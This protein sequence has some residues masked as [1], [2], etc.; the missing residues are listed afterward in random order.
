MGYD[1]TIGSMS[2]RDMMML[3]SRVQWLE[4]GSVKE[5]GGD[6]ISGLWSNGG[7]TCHHNAA[8]TRAINKACGIVC[9]VQVL[10]T[11]S[12]SVATNYPIRVPSCFPCLARAGATFNVHG[13][14]GY[15]IKYWVRENLKKGAKYGRDNR[16]RDITFGGTCF[17]WLYRNALIFEPGCRDVV[18]FA[19]GL[20]MVCIGIDNSWYYWL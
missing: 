19:E 12:G 2:T 3:V 17:L 20:G 16:N 15:G 11:S 10:L 8:G 14:H 9:S 1:S 7:S 5:N 13:V 18:G 4:L 6:R